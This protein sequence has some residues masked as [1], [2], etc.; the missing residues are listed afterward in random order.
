MAG[1]W[2]GACVGGFGIV[3]SFTGHSFGTFGVFGFWRCMHASITY[4]TA[5][6]CSGVQWASLQLPGSQNAVVVV[7]GRARNEPK[8]ESWKSVGTLGLV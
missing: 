7:V 6:E 3:L 1:W 2:V 5:V 8:N 4:R